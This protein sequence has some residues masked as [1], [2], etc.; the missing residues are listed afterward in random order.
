MTN[1]LIHSLIFW[2]LGNKAP[3]TC[4]WICCNS[5]TVLIC[6]ECW[7]TSYLQ[8]PSEDLMSWWPGSGGANANGASTVMRSRK[9]CFSDRERSKPHKPHSRELIS[10]FRDK[11]L[12]PQLKVSNRALREHLLDVTSRARQVENT[13]SAASA[14]FWRSQVKV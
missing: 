7:C 8:I 13:G 1:Q 4:W 6:V 10:P 11:S 12:L 2:D 9:R 5:S 3:D 14:F